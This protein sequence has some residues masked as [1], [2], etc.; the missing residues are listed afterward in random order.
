MPKALVSRPV[1]APAWHRVTTSATS[2]PHSYCPG[3][4]LRRRIAP[5]SRRPRNVIPGEWTEARVTAGCHRSASK[6]AGVPA[7][8]AARGSRRATRGKACAFCQLAECRKPLPE[9]SASTQ[10]YRRRWASGAG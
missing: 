7:G 9:R 4:F 5:A 3:S 1:E 6:V 8:Q 10:E 2:P